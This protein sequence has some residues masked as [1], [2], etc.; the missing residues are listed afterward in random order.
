MKKSI[1]FFVAGLLITGLF[2]FSTTTYQR[3][4]DQTDKGLVRVEKKSGKYVF[5]ECEP[6]GDYEIAFNFVTRVSNVSQPGDFTFAA[7]E[8][9]IKIGERKKKE[10]DGIIIKTGARED[11]AIKFK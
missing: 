10:F 6:V 7:I 11:I 1:T 5:L 2:A 3:S 8:K 9:A 4:F